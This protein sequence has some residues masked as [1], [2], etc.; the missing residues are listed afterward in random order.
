[1]GS[2][3]RARRQGEHTSTT[4]A[5]RANLKKYAVAQDHIRDGRWIVDPDNGV[6]VS[7]RNGR[8]IG[9]RQKNGYI[10]VRLCTRPG[11]LHVLLHRVVWESVNGPITDDGL[12]VNH[13]NGIK[14]DNR[15]ANLELVTPAQNAQHA[16]DTGLYVKA[17]PPVLTGE[18][19]HKTKLTASDIG[20]I[21]LR[22]ASGETCTT[23]ARDY[24][25][26]R[27]QIGRIRRGRHWSHAA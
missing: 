6:I 16:V 22:L 25:V 1:M 10:R 14:F 19:N 23:I 11:S 26:G 24:P 7:R 2:D 13:V 17:P 15:I 9:S 27:S 8:A 5:V 4:F 12:D 20:A 18:R 3:G 21:R